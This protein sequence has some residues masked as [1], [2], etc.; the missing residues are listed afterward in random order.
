MAGRYLNVTLQGF[1][2]FIPLAVCVS[3][4]KNN[5]HYLLI[6]LTFYQPHWG[7]GGVGDSCQS[8]AEGLKRP[9]WEASVDPQ[10]WTG[11]RRAVWVSTS[12]E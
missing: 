9:R 6:T 11:G 8:A 2:S 12:L 5:S 3:T 4:G 10:G 1:R 7:G